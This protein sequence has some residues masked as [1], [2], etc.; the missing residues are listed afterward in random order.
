MKK[1]PDIQKEGGDPFSIHL[2][3]KFNLSQKLLIQDPIGFK[4]G[5]ETLCH[6]LGTLLSKTPSYTNSRSSDITTKP[7]IAFFTFIKLFLTTFSNLLNLNNSYINTV[8]IDS[9]GVIG[10]LL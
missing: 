3:M 9:D 7:S 4:E 5:Y 8:F 10:C 6:M 2:F 1:N